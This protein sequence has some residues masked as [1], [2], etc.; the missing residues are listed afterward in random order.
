MREAIDTYNKHNFII[1]TAV[2]KLINLSTRNQINYTSGNNRNC[3]LSPVLVQASFCELSFS[4]SVN[5]D[6]LV[7]DC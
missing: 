4:V 3:N 5:S 6:K 7:D 2:I 1:S